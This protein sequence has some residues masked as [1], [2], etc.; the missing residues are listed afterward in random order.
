VRLLIELG[1][2]SYLLRGDRAVELAMPLDFAAPV[3]CAFGLPHPRAEAFEVEGFVG[4]RRRGGSANCEVLTLTPH[5]NGT[6]TENVGHIAHDRVAVADCAP[7]PLLMAILLEVELHRLGDLPDSY[8]STCLSDDL[9]ISEAALSDAL[10]RCTP[11][12]VTAS[13]L[14]LRIQSHPGFAGPAA[15]HSGTNPPY[16][17]DQA[18]RWVR[19]KGFDHLLVELPSVDRERDDGALSSHHIFFEDRPDRTITEMIQVPDAL[20][21]GLYALSLRFPRLLTDA[22]PSRPILYPLEKR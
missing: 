16:F 9:V 12:D 5:G 1:E 10:L 21:C 14:V 7:E 15:D 13:A 20:A 8:G 3:V 11:P 6:H 17:T 22:V 19:T 2:S 18:M 4:D